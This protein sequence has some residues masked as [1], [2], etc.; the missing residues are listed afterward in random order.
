MQNSRS[1]HNEK[2]NIEY[3][4]SVVLRRFP[5]GATQF[6][7]NTCINDVMTSP[8]GHDGWK[9]VLRANEGDIVHDIRRA[10]H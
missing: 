7:G 8:G 5:K 4:P 9:L 2:L 3:T 10:G 6:L 1:E